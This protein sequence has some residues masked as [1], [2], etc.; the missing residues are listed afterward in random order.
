MYALFGSHHVSVTHFFTLNRK[1][2]QWFKILSWYRSILIAYRIC[3]SH[4]CIYVCMCVCVYLT[5]CWLNRRSDRGRDPRGILRSNRSVCADVAREILYCYI[6]NAVASFRSFQSYHADSTWQREA[7]HRARNSRSVFAPP[8]L[9]CTHTHTQIA[10]VTRWSGGLS[11]G[12]SE[13]GPETFDRFNRALNEDQTRI[14]YQDAED[15]PVGSFF[16]SCP[17]DIN[18]IILNL[19]CVLVCSLFFSLSVSILWFRLCLRV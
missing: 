18:N 15:R 6:Y 19:L 5:A 7:S 12:I 1:P 10:T 9:T 13:M 8:T 4:S 14:S 16:L 3:L 2:W 11:L 17:S